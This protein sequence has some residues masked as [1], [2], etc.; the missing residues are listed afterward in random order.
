M[1]PGT[2]DHTV[3][4]FKCKTPTPIHGT[5]TN[6]SLKRLKLE[7]RANATSVESELGGGNH[8]YLGLVLTN[9]EYATITANPFVAPAFPGSL[10]SC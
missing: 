1:T 6:S 7:L 8:G 4:Y 3:S 9:T 2:V 10:V 5:P